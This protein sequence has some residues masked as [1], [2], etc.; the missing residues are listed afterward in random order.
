[1][2]KPS[3]LN[4]VVG[5]AVPIAESV[6]PKVFQSICSVIAYSCQHDIKVSDIGVTHREIIDVA[7]NNL[8]EAFLGSDA[9][10]LFWMDSDMSFPPDT[11]VELFKT[12]EETDAKI[13]T[14]V[15]YQRKGKHLPVLWSRGDALA[16]GKISADGTV[17]T[18]QNKYIGAFM[19]PNP[20]KKEPFKAHAAGFGCILVHRS[21]FEVMARPWFRTLPGV[22]SE[23]F[24][25]L[26]NAKDYGFEL[27]VNPV[28]V[29]GHLTDGTF[30]TKREFQEKL[31]PK[32]LVID[33]IIQGENKNETVAKCAD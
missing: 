31:N 1:M 2:A 6:H 4:K 17:K 15:Y 5:V 11:L 32:E 12:V 10:W 27:W 8:A 9:E 23:D 3:Y 13:V 29:L 26:V 18:D 30:V 19:F 33:E 7:R 20:N 28:P 16:S 24:Y 14:G 22:C 21:V 25:F